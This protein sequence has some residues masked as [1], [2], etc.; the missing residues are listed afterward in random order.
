MPGSEEFRPSAT[1][2]NAAFSG[3]GVKVRKIKVIPNEE[4]IRMMI[5][6]NDVLPL[7]ETLLRISRKVLQPPVTWSLIGLFIA[8]F[9]SLRGVLVNIW[10]HR[11]RQ[12]P[13]QFVYDGIY[14]V[15]RQ[16]VAC[17]QIGQVILL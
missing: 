8:S 10:G 6:R 11:G 12:A 4:Q 16:L 7:T 13:L 17:L 1:K 9:P 15:C 5:Q 3:N 14:T 2:N